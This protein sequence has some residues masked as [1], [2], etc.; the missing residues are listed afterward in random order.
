MGA[1]AIVED[2][3]PGG[4]E[5]PPGLNNKHDSQNTDIVRIIGRHF[6]LR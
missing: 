6:L 2:P 3:P 5:V 1:G 4:D